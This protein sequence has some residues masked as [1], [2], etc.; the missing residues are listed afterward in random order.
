MRTEHTDGAGHQNPTNQVHRDTR[1]S[2][3]FP[4]TDRPTPL[5]IAG[6]DGG[7]VERGGGS[8]CAAWLGSSAGMESNLGCCA[9]FAGTAS[10]ASGGVRLATTSAEYWYCSSR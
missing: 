8:A 4:S 10:L 3:T 1:R 5:P 2:P 9:P 6:R 7:G